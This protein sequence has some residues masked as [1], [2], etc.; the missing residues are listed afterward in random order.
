[1]LDQAGTTPCVVWQRRPQRS[2]RSAQ[3]DP[4]LRLHTVD[5][6]FF[7]SSSGLAAVAGAV[8]HWL[9][10]PA[11]PALTPGLAGSPAAPDVLLSAAPLSATL[12]QTQQRRWRRLAELA[13][14][15]RQWSALKKMAALA[16]KLGSSRGALGRTYTCFVGKTRLSSVFCITNR[17]RRTLLTKLNTI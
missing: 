6:L 1:M 2:L 5:A 12:A 13:P 10:P 3:S 7:H 15:Q 8:R 14:R 4:H 9:C 17:L 16:H 11:D